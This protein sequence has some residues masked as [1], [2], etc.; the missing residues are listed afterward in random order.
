MI[1][2]QWLG[3]NTDPARQTFVVDAVKNLTGA[4]AT[5]FQRMDAQGDLLRVAT[6][7][8]TLTGRRAAGTFIPAVNPDGSRNPVAASIRQGKTYRGNAF[9]VNAWYVSA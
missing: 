7:I 4:D 5:V 2:T 1:G 3:Q 6:T 8:R 9:V